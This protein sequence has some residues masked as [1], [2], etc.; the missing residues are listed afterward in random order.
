MHGFTVLVDEFAEK[1]HKL[2]K[3][4]Q[5]FKVK[6]NIQYFQF[7]SNHLSCCLIHEKKSVYALMMKFQVRLSVMLIYG[8][9]FSV[10]THLERRKYFS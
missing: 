9:Q 7:F 1:K 8:T 2:S 5:T 10:R 4:K 6:K 3:L